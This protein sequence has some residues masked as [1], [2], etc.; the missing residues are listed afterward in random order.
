LWRDE[1]LPISNRVLEQD[2][3]TPLARV[4]VY[5]PASILNMQTCEVKT[6]PFF[7]TSDGLKLAGLRPVED[8]CFE[9][10]ESELDDN[11]LYHLYR[12]P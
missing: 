4:M 2:R 11:R 3:R 1:A 12:E 6:P 10:D 5:R 9:V 7:G 8:S